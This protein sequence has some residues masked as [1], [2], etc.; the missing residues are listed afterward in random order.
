MVILRP[1]LV[2]PGDA[3]PEPGP[4]DPAANFDQSLSPG[5]RALVRGEK[6]VLHNTTEFTDEVELT[7]VLDN[8]A[9][10]QELVPKL[11]ELRD[12]LRAARQATDAAQLAIEEAKLNVEY[13][14]PE[15][16]VELLAAE[17]ERKLEALKARYAPEEAVATR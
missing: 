8:I 15:E 5:M 14:T 11:T 6:M 2:D 13:A 3:A 1:T 10:M 16:K 4:F 7:R 12:K 9:R 17:K